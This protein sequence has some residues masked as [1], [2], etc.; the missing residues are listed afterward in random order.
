MATEAPIENMSL[1]GSEAQYAMRRLRL[2]TGV[3]R[4]SEPPR[5]LCRTRERSFRI[6]EF[7]DELIRLAA[8][9]L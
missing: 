7:V 8:K 9:R 5:S 2:R 4:D 1:T 3:F 6:D